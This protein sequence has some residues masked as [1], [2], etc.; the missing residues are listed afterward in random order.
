MKIEMNELLDGAIKVVKKKI[1]AL[2]VHA[3][4]QKAGQAVLNLKAAKSMYKAF[5]KPTKELDEELAFV[6]G[7]LRP[8]L[9]ATEM[10]QVTQAVLHLMHAKAHDEPAYQPA[11]A[12]ATKTN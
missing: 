12:K 7:R 2:T 1:P 3:D 9:G 11:T 6:C 5:G 8:N 10:Q 4:I